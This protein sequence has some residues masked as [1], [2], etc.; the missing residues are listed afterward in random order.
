MERHK[1]SHQKSLLPLRAP[2]L[3]SPCSGKIPWGKINHHHHLSA[4]SST[5]LQKT[6]ASSMSPVTIITSHL[7]SSSQSPRLSILPHNSLW[8]MCGS[9]LILFHRRNQG[10]TKLRQ[11]TCWRS[12]GSEFGH[13]L[14]VLK[15][16]GAREVNGGPRGRTLIISI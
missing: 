5:K 15:S 11:P 14:L 4:S 7:S 12:L 6:L 16:Y 10:K 1:L 9:L 3:D 13:S 8:G 2:A